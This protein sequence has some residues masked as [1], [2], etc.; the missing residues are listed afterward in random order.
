MVCLDFSNMM[1]PTLE[2]GAK[3]NP[4]PFILHF[5][6]YFI[7]ATDKESSIRIIFIMHHQCP[8]L[9]AICSCL[10]H[11]DLLSKG[12]E[13]F[14]QCSPLYAQ[15]AAQLRH[16]GHS[17]WMTEAWGRYAPTMA[18]SLGYCWLN[19]DTSVSYSRRRKTRRCS[20]IVWTPGNWER[21]G[22]SNVS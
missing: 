16:T 3:I 10:P 13:P 20:C 22:L 11:K 17:K 21:P 1:D 8:S 18:M 9:F 19:L 2:L 15:H 7:R 5:L 14:C 4:F 12:S 6:G